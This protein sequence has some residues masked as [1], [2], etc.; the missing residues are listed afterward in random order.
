MSTLAFREMLIA[1][2]GA[3]C[4][5]A[6][7]CGGPQP[8]AQS[9][10]AHTPIAEEA[11]KPSS[12]RAHK[13]HRERAAISGPSI[14]SIEFEP[15]SPRSGD[16]VRAIVQT[17][18]P[19]DQDLWY[20]YQWIV[21]G[22]VVEGNDTSRLNLARITRGTEVEL[23]AV[24]SNGITESEPAFA[25]FSVL[26]APPRIESLEVR[27][28]PPVIPG[29]KIKV[30][31]HAVDPEG[32]TI[33][34]EYH[35][36]LNGRTLRE[37]GPVLST[38]G[39]RRHD[40]IAV[41]VVASDGD[42]TSTPSPPHEIE[43]ANQ[44][45]TIVST[46]GDAADDRLFSYSVEARDPDGDEFFELTLERGPEDMIVDARSNALHWEIEPDVSGSFPVRIVVED[47]HGGRARQSFEITVRSP[48]SPAA[49]ADASDAWKK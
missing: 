16:V 38:D 20:Q 7:A 40:R 24:A 28:T 6:I 34:F 11:P 47:G 45:P 4:A 41:S 32:D 29:M 8:E 42:S 13:E 26:N 14:T 49:P 19:S 21:G 46:P 39:L 43:L 27:P 36:S 18:N 17:R 1:A 9:H 23:V 48:S 15:E 44:P 31:P 2:G 5:V 25:S 12:P 3:A 22:D 37:S 33:D 30:R 35:W 10:K